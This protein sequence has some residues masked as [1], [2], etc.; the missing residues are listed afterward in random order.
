[1]EN[2]MKYWLILKIFIKRNSNLH[3]FMAYCLLSCIYM[4]LFLCSQEEKFPN[5]TDSSLKRP[6][7]NS[8]SN[9]IKTTG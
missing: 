7:E 9:S 6:D 1:M 2:Y 4:K 8:P 5:R 3:H